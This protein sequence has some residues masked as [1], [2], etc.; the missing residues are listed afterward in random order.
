M[1]HF[2]PELYL[3]AM[4]QITPCTSRELAKATETSHTAT[5]RYLKK[6]RQEGLVARLQPPH[7]GRKV[8]YYLKRLKND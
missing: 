8:L 5:L 4:E 1:T 3:T 6:L 7:D 2:S